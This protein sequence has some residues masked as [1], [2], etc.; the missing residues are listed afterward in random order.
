VSGLR[1]A[2]GDQL[3]LGQHWTARL[4]KTAAINR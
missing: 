1:L 2:D 3:A 4:V